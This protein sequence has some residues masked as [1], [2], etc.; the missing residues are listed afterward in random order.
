MSVFTR[1][2]DGVLRLL[3]PASRV[4]QYRITPSVLRRMGAF[5][6]QTHP[7]EM[8]ALLQG[9]HDG[10]TLVVTDLVFQ[11]FENDERSATILIDHG[12]TNIV[13][14]FHSHP[15]PDA[16]PSAADKRLFAQHPGVHVIAGYPYREAN[17]YTHRSR[18]LG[19]ERIP[20]EER[21]R[22]R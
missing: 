15:T 17:V 3:F 7:K 13:G 20:R 4:T 21:S 10:D 11:P 16:R 5:S 12:L 6:W 22:L 8:I 2:F 1:L 18:F 14:T 9:R 19:V